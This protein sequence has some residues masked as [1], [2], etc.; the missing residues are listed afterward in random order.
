MWRCPRSSSRRCSGNR[1]PRTR[2]S[3]RASASASSARGSRG[4]C[5]ASPASIRRLAGR[6]VETAVD[7]RLGQSAPQPYRHPGRRT[8]PVANGVAVSDGRGKSSGGGRGRSDGWLRP[9]GHDRVAGALAPGERRQVGRSATRRTTSLRSIRRPGASSR[10][11][12]GGDHEVGHLRHRCVDALSTANEV[13]ALSAMPH[14]TMWSNQPRS[15]ST[16]RAK[17]CIDRPRLRLHPHCGE[18]A[19]PVAIGA[20]PRHPGTD[21]AARLP[22]RA[23]PRHR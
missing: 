7:A 10:E 2:W 6:D 14:G 4:R 22:R 17:P 11:C 8:G 5:A 1:L 15:T 3:G 12:G 16:L 18:L 23:R 13:T 20:R 19:R 9:L 21:R